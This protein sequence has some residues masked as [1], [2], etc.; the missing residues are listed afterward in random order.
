MFILSHGL[1]GYARDLCYLYLCVNG[2]NYAPL[3]DRLK[4]G[5]TTSTRH[6]STHDFLYQGLKLSQRKEGKIE[7]H[8]GLKGYEG[9]RVHSSLRC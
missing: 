1:V 3:P 7:Y 8:K 2:C 9:E 4:F 5:W 6:H